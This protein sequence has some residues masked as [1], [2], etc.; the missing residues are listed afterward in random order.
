MKKLLLI[1]A[2]ALCLFNCETQKSSEQNIENENNIVIG[3]KD[4]LYS[5][6]L[7]EDR[8][9]WIHLPESAKNAST[10]FAKYPVLYLLDGDGHFYSVTGMIK[11]LSTTNGNTISPEMIVIGI[12]NTDRTRDLTPTHVN[13]MFGDTI[14]PKTSGGGKKFLSF[15]EKELIPYVEKTYPASSYK[16]FVGHSFGG[17]AVIDALVDRPDLF[18]NYVAIDP[19]L[20]WD[21][22]EL[23]K[24]ANNVLKD[25]KYEGKSLYVG[26]A[27]TMDEDMNFKEV[28]KDTSEATEHIRSILK[29]VKTTD[30]IDSKGLN[31]TWKYYNNDS[32]GSVPLI[33]EY[34]ALRFL[35]S[36]YELKGLDK[37]FDPT[38][39]ASVDD[40]INLID[41]HYKNVSTNFGYEV[42]PPESF[43]N[44]IG[45]AFI[46]SPDTHAKANALFS[47]NVQNYPNSSNVYDSMGD[48]YLVQK[49]SL[50]ALEFFTKALEVGDNDF[51]QEKIDMLKEHLKLNN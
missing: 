2:I 47:M 43:I 35:F 49:D 12:P 23:L 33:T 16:T 3:K 48:C 45:Y 9:I 32:H 4:V 51:S 40:L 6:I 17:L 22:Q 25:N 37:F 36:W 8:E 46:E 21:N 11:Q 44:Q 20:W 30:S 39:T 19:S 15:I 50:K 34:D 7:K 29:F 42:L 41:S 5:D 10:S 31:F 28:E 13:E 1:T 18:N 27:N 26:I 38:S 24:R 14:F